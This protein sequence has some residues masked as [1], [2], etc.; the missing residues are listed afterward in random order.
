MA[1]YSLLEMTQLI[2]SAMESDEVSSYAD[3]TESLSVAN[4]IRRVYNDMIS[5]Q[6]LPEF[7][8]IFELTASGDSNYPI[9]MYMPED[10][11]TMLWL[12]YNSLD[13]VTDPTNYLPLRYLELEEFL[14]RMYLQNTSET[15]V[16]TADLGR[17][18]TSSTLKLIY[19]NDKNPEFYTTIDDN[20]VLFD[21]YLASVDST[22]QSSKTSAYGIYNTDYVMDDNFVPRLNDQHFSL[23]FNKALAVSFAEVK[24]VTNASAEKEVKK[25]EIRSEKR[26]YQNPRRSW[27]DTLPNYGRK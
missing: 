20:T 6:D 22:L 17:S 3:T 13:T 9:V 15:G 8:D 24:Q 18:V 19:R 11:D 16:Y 25:Q 12:K 14:R 1:K 4:V 5:G 27:F 2:L 23:F 26:R 7:Y 21:S 10:V